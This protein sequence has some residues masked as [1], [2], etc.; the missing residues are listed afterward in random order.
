MFM[1]ICQHFNRRSHVGLPICHPNGACTRSLFL[2]LLLK[3]GRM[4]FLFAR[5][6]DVVSSLICLFV[7]IED[8]LFLT[9]CHD[10]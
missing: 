2:C 5:M 6:Q 8:M 10:T 7:K 3:D 4:L 9:I 1:N